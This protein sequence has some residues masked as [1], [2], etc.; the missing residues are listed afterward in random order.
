MSDRTVVDE[1]ISDPRSVLAPQVTI[2]GGDAMAGAMAPPSDRDPSEPTPSLAPLERTLHSGTVVRSLAITILAVLA[3]VYTLYFGRD[4]FIPVT[5]AVL[6]NFLVSPLIRS[7]RQF[8]V[9]PGLSAAII[10]AGFIAILSVGI[11]ELATPARDWLA[12]APSALTKAR[13]K[14]S[15]ILQ[16]MEQVTQTAEQVARVTSVTDGATRRTPRVVVEGPTLGARFFGTTESIASSTIEVL[17]LLFFLLAAGD[18]FLQKLIKVLPSLQDKRMAV[19]IARK[20]EASISAYLIT[21]AVLNIT[22][23]A[24]VAV[25]LYFLGMPNP[26]L[27]GS[28]VA[29]LEFVPYLG[30]TTIVIV[31]ALASLTVFDSVGH[32]LL[33]PGAFLCINLIQGNV[34]SPLVLGHRLALNP[35]AIFLGLAF[36]WELWGI[37]GAFLAVPLMATLK[38]F[39]DHIAVLAPIGEFLGQREDTERRSVV[40]LT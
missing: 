16:P 20:T 18:L 35:V 40:R 24:C 1:K 8:G 22:E 26:L 39:C 3:V 15:A 5:L 28:L 30:A 36:W 19:E 12:A 9:P 31:F 4:F 37:A 34:I 23:G 10:I 14:L 11:Y 32:A 13:V 25:V 2:R 7:A 33:V 38:I 27:W 6:L 21:S 17:V 29:V